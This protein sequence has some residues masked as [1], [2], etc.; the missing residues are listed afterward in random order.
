MAM[1][2]CR[3]KGIILRKMTDKATGF[4]V[5][6]SHPRCYAAS[7]GGC[8]R[9]LSGEHYISEAVLRAGGGRSVT[10][11]TYPWNRGGAKT[12]IGIPSFK[13]KV[14]CQ[15]HNTLLSPADAAAHRLAAGLRY[16]QLLLETTKEE[17]SL[18]ASEAVVVSGD[19][20][21]SWLLKTLLTHTFSSVFTSAGRPVAHPSDP[22]SVDL[23]F[24][25]A[26]WPNRWG[27]YVAPKSSAP[28][29]SASLPVLGDLQPI[30]MKDGHLGGGLI[31]LGGITWVLS[32]F[33]PA[34]GD[35]G[36]FDGAAYQPGIIQFDFG[37]VAKELVFTWRD[38]K[39]HR[40]VRYIGSVQPIA[41]P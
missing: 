41:K 19:D 14:L 37:T 9:K 20:F 28:L 8:S 1:A 34:D 27:L 31:C 25:S 39:A 29:S 33:R 23:L 11:D 3:I 17:V 40:G 21:Q 2:A 26:P 12:T 4:R 15:N 30:V 35:G 7:R 16:F 5:S 18:A 10:T 24:G 13:A 36:P 32:L 22:I 6:Y 38:A